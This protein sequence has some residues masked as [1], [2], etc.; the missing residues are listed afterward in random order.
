MG[1]LAVVDAGERYDFGCKDTGPSAAIHVDDPLFY[2]YIVT[3][4]AIGGA[5]AYM[6]GHFHCDDLTS[7]IRIMALNRKAIDHME[8]KGGHLWQPVLRMWHWLNRNNYSGSQKNIAT[9]Y[10][11]GNDFF[12]LFLDPTLTY[13]CGVFDSKEASMEQASIAKYDRLCRKLGLTKD[14]H[15]LEIGTGWGGFAIHAATHYG[16]RVTTTTISREQYDLAQQRVREAGVDDRVELLFKDYRDLE[17]TYDKLV[18]IEMIEAVGIR[19]WDDYFRVCGERLGPE[20]IMALQ[21]ISV[22]DQDFANSKK[23][24]DFIKRYIFPGGQLVSHAALTQAMARAS[25]L[26]I[27]HFEDITAHYA[28]TLGRWHDRMLENVDRM[29]AMGLPDRF[30][31]MWEYYLCYCQGS[32]AER[33]IGVFQMVFEKPLCRRDPLLGELTSTD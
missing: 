24:V 21:A 14:D 6:D 30:L 32:F 2:R 25:D 28:L 31:A 18:S 13:S 12:E 10:D 26:H 4:G 33:A 20:G 15:V 17:G 1:E 3:G 9:H 19:H 11:L 5:E 8:G 22:R 29:R 16:C 27:T 7:V 23:S